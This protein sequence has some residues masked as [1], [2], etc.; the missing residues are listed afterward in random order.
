MS[1]GFAVSDLCKFN[2]AHMEVH[3]VSVN[4][5]FHYLRKTVPVARKSYDW[6]VV[7][8]SNTP[9][10][11]LDLYHFNGCRVCYDSGLWQVSQVCTL[12]P[13]EELGTLQE[14]AIFIFINNKSVIVM[15]DVCSPMNRSQ[16]ID[17]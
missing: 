5:A 3:Y 13:V 1:I 9:T 7:S 2:N 4:C 15:G 16:H 10:G 14:G 12:H 17:I 6:M 11:L 8:F